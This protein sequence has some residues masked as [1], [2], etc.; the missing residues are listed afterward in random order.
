MT[1]TINSNAFGQIK[2]KGTFYRA[3]SDKQIDKGNNVEVIN[4]SDNQGLY[5]FVKGIEENN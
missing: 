5:Y 1:K 2:Y 4:K 3:K